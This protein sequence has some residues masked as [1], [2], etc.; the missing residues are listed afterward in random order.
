MGLSEVQR[1]LAQLYIDASLRD[2]F[3]ADATVIGVSLGLSTEESLQ[4]QRVP[5]PQLEQFAGSLRGK[6]R[7]QVRRILPMAAR[8]LGGTFIAIFERYVE[9]SP[10]RGSKADIDDAVAFVAVIGRW[11]DP[12]E[13]A[14]AVDLARYELA[15][16]Q[17][18]RA[19]W[20]PS[21]R[22]FRYPVARLAAGREPKPVVP[23]ATFA[24]WWRFTRRGSVRHLVLSVPRLQ[25]SRMIRAL[26]FLRRRM[27]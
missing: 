21:G 4:L 14:W 7:D 16:R 6:R 24:C 23:R 17:A 5:R 15:W 9:E 26:C 2:R 13:P 18:E 19:G 12:I 3:F 20:M 10:P 8:T 1:V 22:A 11:A 25:H 27:T